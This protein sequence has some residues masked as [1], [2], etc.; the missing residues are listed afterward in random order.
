MSG[1]AIHD[2]FIVY[3]FGALLFAGAS[4]VFADQCWTADPPRGAQ[5]AGLVGLA[6]VLWPVLAV[7]V[8]QLVLIELV[9][10]RVQSAYADWSPAPFAVGPR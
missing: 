4:T 5:R 6:G 7:G 1:I 9:A 10:R 3:T 2:W 8:V